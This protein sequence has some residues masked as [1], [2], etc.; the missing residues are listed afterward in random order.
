MPSKCTEYQWVDCPSG[1]NCQGGCRFR[2]CAHWTNVSFTPPRIKDLSITFEGETIA[3]PLIATPAE[4]E[5]ATQD[6]YWN[7]N[8]GEGF[9][10][11][12]TVNG[13]IHRLDRNN[14]FASFFDDLSDNEKAEYR[15]INAKGHCRNWT[16]KERD[17]MFNHLLPQ[18]I[19]GWKITYV[20]QS[21]EEGSGVSVK[22][23]ESDS[24]LEISGFN[25]D[26]TIDVTCH[27]DP[28]VNDA[29]LVAKLSGP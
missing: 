5:T 12:T 29:I 20:C 21:S 19:G 18:S 26:F 24:T 22:K 2:I 14:F 16:Q 10:E 8:T 4:L 25:I 15:R 9:V 23:L 28:D 3:D 11:Y 7:I 17:R 13:N 27:C 6:C 1:A